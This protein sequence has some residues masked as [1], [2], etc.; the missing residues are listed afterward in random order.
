VV[1]LIAFWEAPEFAGDSADYHCV[2]RVLRR[3]KQH[4]LYETAAYTHVAMGF[5]AKAESA[6][7]LLVCGRRYGLMIG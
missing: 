2:S 4:D 1:I 3:A 6:V 5:F 7:V